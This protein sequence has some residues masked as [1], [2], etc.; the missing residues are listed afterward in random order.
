MAL[1]EF[2]LLLP[3]L[4]IL[5]FGTIDLGRAYQLNNRLKN[6]AREGA[7]YA[8][9]FPLRQLPGSGQC[10]NPDNITYHA[11]REL[12]D[13]SGTSYT[14]AISPTV[15]SCGAPSTDLESGDEITVTASRDF[16]IIT[17]FVGAF[18]SSPIHVSESV[19]VVIL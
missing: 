17:P 8:Q 12:G 13:G 4:A 7:A 2:A 16:H 6:A 9:Q 5:V 11:Q 10:S 1:V 15:A 14:I 3:F 19:T 18:I